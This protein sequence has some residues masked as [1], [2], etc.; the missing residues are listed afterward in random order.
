MIYILKRFFGCQR[1]LLAAAPTKANPDIWHA[2][3][4]E[5]KPYTLRWK[6]RILRI[7]A[8]QLLEFSN[9]IWV[10][11][12]DDNDDLHEWVADRIRNMV[13]PKGHYNACNY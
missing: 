13:N 12:D 8:T 3:V 5:S 1:T 11:V 2:T 6:A 4:L 9:R 10:E 7:S